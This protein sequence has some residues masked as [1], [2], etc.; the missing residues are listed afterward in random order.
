MAAPLTRD[1][2]GLRRTYVRV[3]D[4]ATSP[5]LQA[6]ATRESPLD[7]QG[8]LAAWGQLEAP[9]RTIFADVRQ[10]AP[11]HGWEPTP[12][13][14]LA[15]VLRDEV[16]RI[17]ETAAQPALALGGG[18]DGA[19]VLALWARSGVPLP[20]VLTV[21]TGLAAYDEVDAARAIA[22]SVGARVVAVQAPPAEVLACLDEA[23]IACETPL[24][25]LHPVT[26]LILARAAR[27]FGFDTLVTGDG[28]HA[29]FAG[30]ADGDSVPRMAALTEA[31]GLT[32][33]SPFLA[34]PV[35]C[36]AH[37]EKN[38][39]KSRLRAIAETLDLPSGVVRS[40]GVRRMF[41]ALDLS[42]AWGTG[43]RSS[44]LALEAELPW[45]V[46]SDRD[47]VGWLTLE[48]LVSHVRG[49]G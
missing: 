33:A 14:A 46:E 37:H 34:E 30:A 17:A 32:L 35:V 38:L 43:A 23:V 41:P 45:R 4:A 29:V 47:R 48:R 1:W 10:L 49:R 3:A 12:A 44:A 9:E 20:T 13:G 26:R 24:S 15:D 28:A 16:V 5:S 7:R 11:A 19:V 40:D 22:E 6:L 18:L 36:A 39:N 31:A 42:E 27:K 21:E 2:H 8:V 25:N